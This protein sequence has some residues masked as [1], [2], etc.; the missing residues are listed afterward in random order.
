[1]NSKG[2]DDADMVKAVEAYVET[3]CEGA[4]YM[5]DKRKED[6]AAKTLDEC[7]RVLKSEVKA[8]YP[9]FLYKIYYKQAEL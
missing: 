3:C 7:A 4:S 5:L 9:R 8:S 1:M 2:V 6:E